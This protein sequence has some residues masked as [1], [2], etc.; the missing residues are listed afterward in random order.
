MG[1]GLSCDPFS[2]LFGRRLQASVGEEGILWVPPMDVEETKDEVVVR[3]EL[4]GLKREEIHLQAQGD[5]LV[6][7]G[8]R[9]QETESKDKTVHLVERAYGKFQ[10]V[11]SLPSEVDGARASASYENGVLVIRLP[12]REEI[13]PKEIAIEVK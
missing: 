4:P 3:A 9:R 1:Y 10:R 13:K 12:K 6:L 5:T 7:T 11:V 8:E 2:E